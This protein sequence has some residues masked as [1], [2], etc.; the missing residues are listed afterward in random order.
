LAT[1][2]AAAAAEVAA[3]DQVIEIPVRYDGPDLTDVAKLTG[4]SVK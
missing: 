1:L 3:S 2:P 4:L